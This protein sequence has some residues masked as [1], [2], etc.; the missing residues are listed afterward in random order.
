MQLLIL[1]L[2]KATKVLHKA[3]EELAVLSQR[4]RKKII[5]IYPE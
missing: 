4:I 2:L 3:L 1:S 5:R